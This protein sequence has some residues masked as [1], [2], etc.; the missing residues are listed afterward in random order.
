MKESNKARTERLKREQVAEA[1]VVA[2]P[3]RD[4][5]VTYLKGLCTITGL[6]LLAIFVVIL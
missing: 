1:P 5:D 2:K 3:K 6:F 4:H